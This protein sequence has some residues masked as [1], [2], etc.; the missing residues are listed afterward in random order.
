MAKDKTDKSHASIIDDDEI[1]GKMDE[2]VRSMISSM[3]KSDGGAAF[4]NEFDNEMA[5]DPHFKA[6]FEK[7]EKGLAKGD[8]EAAKILRQEVETLTNSI[9]TMTID[10]DIERDGDSNYEFPYERVAPAMLRRA[11]NSVP[12]RL[13]KQYR[14][15]QLSEFTSPSDGKRPGFQLAYTDEERK[16]TPEE[17]KNLAKW[18][19]VLAKQFF[20]VPNDP[21]P[22]FTKWLQFAYGDFFDMDKVA[23]EVLRQDA[24][25]SPK[26]NF[27]G[28][29]LFFVLVDAGTIKHVIPK[30]VE[31][32]G[33]SRYEPYRW[34]APQTMNAGVSG[35]H[36]ISFD[37]KDEIRY[38]QVDNN[39]QTRQY[40]SEAQMM[41]HH[42]F[43]TTDLRE[44][45]QGYSIV[46]QSLQ[47]IRYIIDSIIYNATRRSAGQMPKGM[48]H[49]EGATEDGYSRREM[50]L[51]RKL[52]WGIASGK[53]DHWKYPIV[54]TPKGVKTN[55]VRFHESSKEMED[56][57]WF[58]TLLS[59]MC[60]FSGL[61]PEQLELASQKSTLGKAKL[62]AKEEEE[63][64]AFRSQDEG[65]RFFLNYMR[66]I[67][68]SS[69]AIEEMT[70]DEGIEMRWVGLD[71]EDEAKKLEMDLK[72]LSTHGSMND[73]LVAQDKEPFKLEFGDVN[74][75]D[76][77]GIGNQQVQAVILE[78]LRAVEAANNQEMGF[79]Q[80]GFDGEENEDRM[81][82]GGPSSEAGND[83]SGP[84]YLGDEGFDDEQNNGPDEKK[85]DKKKKVGDLDIKKAML[86]L[87]Q[88]PSIGVTFDA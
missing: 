54:G 5:S 63:G 15:H 47:I 65:L 62:F 34:D 29:P 58:S 57:M 44:Q 88:N 42:A 1:M 84:D 77:P 12:A 40:F 25:M 56:F 32:Q 18:E 30:M 82:E 52:I 27:R 4:L 7:F 6:E 10:P 73:L 80:D 21:R 67:I 19:M 45:F 76:I 3:V 24:S 66:S 20:F 14:F 2:N 26:H 38:L 33:P 68:N 74:I 35:S 83:Q 22:N 36:G 61:S 85:P 51:F 87:Q 72:V 28:K 70:G 41:L 11:G 53:K 23:I 71:V 31:T 43:G 60:S 81:P 55:F 69:G 78:A 13:I 16:V 79:G 75:Y 17:K 46:E 64:A 9:M 49:V 86:H 37:Y 39:G 48:I 59:I 50:A 8:G